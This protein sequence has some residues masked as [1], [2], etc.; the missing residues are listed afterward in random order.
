[1]LASHR[2]WRVLTR[3][4]INDAISAT[5]PPEDPHLKFSLVRSPDQRI[6]DRH[7]TAPIAAPFVTGFSGWSAAE[8]GNFVQK[9]DCERDRQPDSIGTRFRLFAILDARSAED[10]AVNLVHK[11]EE[12]MEDAV[13]TP[14]F[15]GPSVSL[16]WVG[17]R[18]RFSDFIENLGAAVTKGNI[19]FDRNAQNSYVGK[20]GIW[21][22]DHVGHQRSAQYPAYDPEKPWYFQTQELEGPVSQDGVFRWAGGTGRQVVFAEVDGVELDSIQQ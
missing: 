11:Y 15:S 7:T 6:L 8:L 21:R 22:F 3:K 1:M 4:V 12:I 19:F 2:F 18:I 14:D 20:D 16:A 10:N 17:A 5:G 9:L 13:E